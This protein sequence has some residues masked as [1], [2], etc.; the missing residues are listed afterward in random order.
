M[1]KS[2][3]WLDWLQRL[4]AAWSALPQPV[5][6]LIVAGLT[7]IGTY[8]SG[9]R[10]NLLPIQ[11]WG[12][13]VGLTIAVCFAYAAIAWVLAD[14]HEK[15]SGAIKHDDAV[16]GLGRFDALAVAQDRNIGA[17]FYTVT[18]EMTCRAELFAA[19]P[20]VDMDLVV[21][22]LSVF[23]MELVGIDGRIRY[24]N[25]PLSLA[26]ELRKP[27]SLTHG[28]YHRVFLRQWL[29]KDVV[30]HMVKH[31]P[32]TS[33]LGT[34]SFGLLFRY[35]SPDSTPKTHRIAFPDGLF[36]VAPRVV[37]VPN[38]G[39]HFSV[40]I[41]T[42]IDV[43]NRTFNSKVR[44]DIPVEMASAGSATIGIV[45]GEQR[46]KLVATGAD[47]TGRFEAKADGVLLVPQLLKAFVR[48]GGQD[49]FSD[50]IPP[51]FRP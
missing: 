2:A 39:K 5:R 49:Y 27:V 24:Q 46:L 6:A 40:E 15:R 36:A 13:V 32:D 37:T 1:S 48:T 4:Q 38:A 50:E 20:F 28:K 9:L 42:S 21:I 18:R 47:Q 51:T 34:G 10:S 17:F 29:T 23:D 44:A 25:E 14:A 41:S 33:L 26:P 35:S 30:G 22:N 31:T 12:L 43:V 3:W 11:L 8:L 7:A 16:N 45:S 19:E